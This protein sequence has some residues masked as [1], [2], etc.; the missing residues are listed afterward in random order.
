VGVL[1]KLDE[2]LTSY[3]AF[4]DFDAEDLTNTVTD[5]SEIV[6]QVPIR[7]AD[8]WD[9]FKGI[10]DKKDIEALERHLAPKDIRDQFYERVSQYARTLQEAK[11]ADEF[12]KEFTQ[13]QIEFY[14]NELKRFMSLRQSVQIRYAEIISYKEYEPRVRKLLDSY[15]SADEVQVVTNE[16]NIFDQG[17]V[18]EA[19]ASYGKTPASKADFIA[20]NMKKVINENM[21]KDE[22]FYK[23]FS[24]MIEETI[25]A[26]QDGRL[27]EAEYLQQIL[28]VRDDL[29]K[30][31]QEGIPTSIQQDPQARAFF[32]AVSEVLKSTHGKQKV[33]QIA[34]H[35]ATAGK[36]ISQ[37]VENLTIR[38]WKK[39]LDVQR[40]MENEI[41]DFLIDHRKN[42]GIEI[43][44]DEIDE[45]LNKCLKIAQHNY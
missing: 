21:E 7:H 26:F 34:D 5:M 30:G 33:D 12:Y 22:A 16:V 27:T 37:I 6:R 18:N 14:K 44:F 45:I 29:E 11:S 3:A 43:T 32:G 1:G 17:Q 25:K 15:V 40:K 8:V 13:Q 19:L 28:E 9:I 35:L 24:E 39:N 42:L 23:K 20:N 10:S 41:E 4:E 38:D 31:H 36:E 2:A